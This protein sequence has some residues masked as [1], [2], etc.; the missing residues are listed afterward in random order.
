MNTENQQA[1]FKLQDDGYLVHWTGGMYYSQADKGQIFIA[2]Q[3]WI[4]EH[5]KYSRD[6]LPKAGDLV[7]KDDTYTC[8][9]LDEAELSDFNLYKKHRA[10]DLIEGTR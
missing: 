10:T 3:E 9:Q 4:D 5:A 1:L 2:T 7:Y 6:R 8:V